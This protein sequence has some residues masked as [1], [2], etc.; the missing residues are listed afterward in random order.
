MDE[1]IFRRMLAMHSSPE[2][3][4]C[5]AAVESIAGYK[6]SAVDR[7][8]FLYFHNYL[9]N[10][11]PKFITEWRSSPTTEARYTAFANGILHDV[12]NTFACV[13]YHYGRL[14]SIETSV[15]EG[16]ERHDYRRAL[17]TSTLAL[18]NTLILDFEY[19]AFILA[20][21]RCL[22]Y[23][24]RAVCTYFKNDFHSFRRLSKF[25]EKLTPIEVSAPLIEVH[26][27]YVP[28][29]EFVLSDGERKSLRDRISHYG[30]VQ[31]G[32]VNLSRRGFLLAGG[33]ENLGSGGAHGSA[34]L[35]EVL[36]AHVKNLRGCLRDMILC[37]VDS[38]GRH[39]A[40]TA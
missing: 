31:A 30:Y 16:L 36:D 20:L 11:E 9:T 12:Q 39:E 24:A 3:Q 25:L 23:L 8:P 38:I 6:L 26:Q 32:T 33:G 19:Q 27:R 7:Q 35:S 34:T 15:V 14:K 18:G 17:G 1:E 5:L 13:L 4:A 2:I 40:P 10:P 29:F 28:N 21:R 37:Y 22:D